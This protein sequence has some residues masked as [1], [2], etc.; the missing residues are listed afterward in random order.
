MEEVEEIL[1]VRLFYSMCTWLTK[2]YREIRYGMRK[3][4]N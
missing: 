1:I 3:D 2:F 4:I